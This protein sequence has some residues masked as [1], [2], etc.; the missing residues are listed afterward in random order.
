MVLG[1]AAKSAGG[2]KPDPGIQTSSQVPSGA[3]RCLQGTSRGSNVDSLD[4]CKKAGKDGA[5]AGN[6]GNRSDSGSMMEARLGKE[7]LPFPGDE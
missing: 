5:G 1:L 3:F 4:T 6:V 2:Q 7:E